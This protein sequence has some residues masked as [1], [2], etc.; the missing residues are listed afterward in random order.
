M[1]PVWR[2]WHEPRKGTFAKFSGED[3][4]PLR[5]ALVRDPRT[6]HKGVNP[7]RFCQCSMVLGP[8]T[9]PARILEGVSAYDSSNAPSMGRAWRR[10][11][12]RRGPDADPDS[13]IL[14]VFHILHLLAERSN[15]QTLWTRSRQR[16]CCIAED[17][18]RGQEGGARPC[19][20]TWRGTRSSRHRNGRSRDRWREAPIVQDCP[21]KDR[22]SRAG[23]GNGP[24][25]ITRI[26]AQSH[27]V[28]DGRCCVWSG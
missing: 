18:A 1:D 22:A 14:F 16:L 23:A 4:E 24:S 2:R 21:R 11:H 5:E 13:A 7:R 3:C 9:S 20:F 8:R 25:G 17:S 12:R 6:T 10:A 19:L 28:D 26:D 15:R 27:R